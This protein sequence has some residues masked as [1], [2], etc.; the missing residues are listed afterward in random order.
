MKG[1]VDETL[2]YD[3]IYITLQS[4]GTRHFEI[5]LFPLDHRTLLMDVDIC[6]L[7]RKKKSSP[8]TG[9]TGS[10]FWAIASCSIQEKRYD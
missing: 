3:F 8:K 2:L 4:A 6:L 5:C 10:Y 9:M 1:I 7:L